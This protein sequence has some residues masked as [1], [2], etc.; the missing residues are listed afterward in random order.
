VRCCVGYQVGLKVGFGET[1]VEVD[2]YAIAWSSFWLWRLSGRFH[3]ILL[4]TLLGL[5]G[6]G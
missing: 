5:G 4:A 2:S 6:V 3:S 1:F